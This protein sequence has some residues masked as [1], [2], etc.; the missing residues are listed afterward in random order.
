MPAEPVKP[1]SHGSRSAFAGTYSDW[2][3]SA[4]GTTNPS[5]PRR[6][7]SSRSF[8]MRAALC[9]PS[10]GSSKVWKRAMLEE[11]SCRR[12]NLSRRERSRRRGSAV[13]VRGSIQDGEGAPSADPSPGSRFARVGPLP[14]GGGC[15]RAES[16]GRSRAKAHRCQ[17]ARRGS[18][19]PGPAHILETPDTWRPARRLKPEALRSCRRS[20]LRTGPGLSELSALAQVRRAGLLPIRFQPFRRPRRSAGRSDQ[21]GAIPNTRGPPNWPQAS[22]AR[23]LRDPG[24]GRRSRPT[25]TTPRESVPRRT[26]CAYVG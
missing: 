25:L 22:R 24:R 7:S 10:A 23:G 18:R 14:P 5:S 1:V 20:G 3:S 2:C 13:R 4:R 17:R 12:S 15:G 11:S 8:A 6:A 9:A 26:G 21:T 19:T 16:P